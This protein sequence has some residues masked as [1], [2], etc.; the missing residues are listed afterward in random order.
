M[1]DL[2]EAPRRMSVADRIFEPQEE[3]ETMTSAQT[4]YAPMRSRRARPHGLDRALMRASLAMLLWARR[5]ADRTAISYEE[6]TLRHQESLARD[7]REAQVS[8]FNHRVF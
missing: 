6:H 5:H 2:L 1:T 3:V 7:R 4:M 8:R